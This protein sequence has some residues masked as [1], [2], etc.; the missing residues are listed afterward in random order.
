MVALFRG[1]NSF[2]VKEYI[3]LGMELSDRALA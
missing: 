3:G 1:Q 2:L